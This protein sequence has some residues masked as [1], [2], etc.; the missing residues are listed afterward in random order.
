MTPYSAEE[1]ED[2]SVVVARKAR[3]AEAAV[4]TTWVYETSKP[5]LWVNTISTSLWTVG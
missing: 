2:V 3:I 5:D 4:T 1:D